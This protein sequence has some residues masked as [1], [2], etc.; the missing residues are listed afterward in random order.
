MPLCAGP[1]SLTVDA[2]VVPDIT[3]GNV[4]MPAMPVSKKGH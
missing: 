1:G 4:N 2:S 3:S